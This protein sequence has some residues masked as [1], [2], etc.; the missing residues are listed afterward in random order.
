M[1]RFGMMDL[2]ESHIKAIVDDVK[3]RKLFGIIDEKK[4]GII[5]YAV[6]QEHAMLIMK[7]LQKSHKDKR[8][9]CPD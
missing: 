5:G 4:G 2:N 7:A 9:A 6:G 8:S 3:T 1:Y